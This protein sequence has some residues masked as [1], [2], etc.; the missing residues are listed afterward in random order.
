M[1]TRRLKAK[2][3]TVLPPQFVPLSEENRQQAVTAIAGMIE[4]WWDQQQPNRV[5]TPSPTDTR[6]PRDI[7]G[8]PS[9][10]QPGTPTI[11][12]SR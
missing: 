7:A 12:A 4:E 8:A 5:R 2:N 10:S 9:R 3:I 11:S 1:V 6:P